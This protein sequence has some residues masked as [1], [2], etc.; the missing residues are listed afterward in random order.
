M[1]QDSLKHEQAVAARAQWESA[2]TIVDDEPC[3]LTM[4][5][6][7]GVTHSTPVLIVNTNAIKW[8][9]S[10]QAAHDLKWGCLSY[11]YVLDQIMLRVYDIGEDGFGKMLVHIREPQAVHD[12]KGR[13]VTGGGEANSLFK[14]QVLL[15]ISGGMVGFANFP[16]CIRMAMLC[17]VPHTYDFDLESSHFQAI[18]FRHGRDKFPAI[19]KLVDDKVSERARLAAS[20]GVTVDAIKELLTSFIYLSSGGSWLVKHGKPKFSAELYDLR[21]CLQDV[22]TQEVH[23]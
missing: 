13:L 19:T 21:R 20:M 12:L 16:Y 3:V 18:L 14:M 15:G 17:G 6:D 23:V 11:A 7:E 8:F 9:M 5:D 2:K 4:P 1:Y 10:T 22:A